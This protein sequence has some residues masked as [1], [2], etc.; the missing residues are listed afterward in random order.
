MLLIQDFTSSDFKN[1]ESFSN[2]FM[3][4]DKDKN[5]KFNEA[6]KC[7]KSIL[8]KKSTQTISQYSDICMIDESKFNIF[9]II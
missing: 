6:I 7:L 2:K 5:N 1:Q 8:M 4:D 9:L 3:K